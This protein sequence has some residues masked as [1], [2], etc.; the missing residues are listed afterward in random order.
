M[1]IFI[2]KEY[3]ALILLGNMTVSYPKH[4]LSVVHV[5]VEY[6]V[7]YCYCENTYESDPKIKTEK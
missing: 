3:P 2:M 6:V 7:G 1:V 4:I 5:I